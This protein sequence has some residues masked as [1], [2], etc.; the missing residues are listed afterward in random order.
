M[1]KAAIF[2]MD[3]VIIDSHPVH[4]RAWRASQQSVGG[5][6]SDQELEI[7]VDGRRRDEIIKFFLGELDQRQIRDFGEQKNKF[8]YEIIE[9][10]GLMADFSEFA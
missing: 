3:G 7:V 9:S 6:V 4:K 5:E 2:D 10:V 1:L 8:F